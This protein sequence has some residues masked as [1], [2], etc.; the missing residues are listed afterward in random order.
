MKRLAIILAVL[1]IVVPVAANAD[2][3]YRSR[4]C[5]P[6]R[7]QVVYRYKDVV[8]EKVVYAL[9]NIPLFQ[10]QYTPI[11]YTSS[12]STTVAPAS[13]PLYYPQPYALPVV[14]QQ[15][16]YAQPQALVQKQTH[17]SCEDKL[18]KILLRLERIES[19]QPERLALSANG[20][21]VFVKRCSSCHDSKDNAAK[22]KGHVFFDSGVPTKWDA[23]TRELFYDQITTGA[24]PKGGKLTEVELGDAVK[25][26]RGLRKSWVKKTNG[27][28]D[29][30]NSGSETKPPP[31]PPS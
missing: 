14:A 28:G 4:S 21:S 29:T 24:M 27:N 31:P 15:S 3:Y 11:A 17:S 26:L 2:G 22:G 25:H 6:V 10:L 23:D 9:Q 18:E 13:A 7:E 30:G 1:L 19:G 12:Y 5:Y 16:Y 8:N 20:D